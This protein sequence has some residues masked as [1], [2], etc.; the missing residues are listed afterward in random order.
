MGPF[1][2]DGDIAPYACCL[3]G[4]QRD[5]PTSPSVLCFTN[6]I[7]LI[8]GRIFFPLG[9]SAPYSKVPK[10][11]GTPFSRSTMP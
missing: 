3:A 1:A 4:E 5:R 10:N 9:K 7:S 6:A 8:R 2:G 11:R